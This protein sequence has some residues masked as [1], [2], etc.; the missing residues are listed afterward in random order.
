MADIS[1]KQSVVGP[2]AL[3]STAK[4]TVTVV[5]D[6]NSSPNNDDSEE[7]SLQHNSPL[8]QAIDFY[9]NLSLEKGL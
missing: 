1:V 2:P 3:Q 7:A 5:Q 8:K 4:K 6:E 9:D